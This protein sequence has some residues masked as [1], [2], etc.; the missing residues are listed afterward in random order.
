MLVHVEGKLG[1]ESELVSQ[2]WD[3]EV[4]N[5]YGREMVECADGIIA[6]IISDISFV[7][8]EAPVL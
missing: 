5:Q 8:R 2:P 1:L 4:R 3:Q 7:N 6:Q